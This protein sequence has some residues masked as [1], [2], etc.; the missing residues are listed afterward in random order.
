MLPIICV[1][2]GGACYRIAEKRRK[3]AA[4]SSTDLFDNGTFV[5]EGA[6]LF[7]R[8]HGPGGKVYVTAPLPIPAAETPP[9]EDIRGVP[10]VYSAGEVS[11]RAGFK[12][13]T[14]E[15]R[16]STT[17]RDR[18]YLLGCLPPARRA[19][20][21]QGEVVFL[22]ATTATDGRFVFIRFLGSPETVFLGTQLLQPDR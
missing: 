8:I 12:R 5:C 13:A 7:R 6:T 11:A 22:N 2:L 10:V 18:V 16:A 9:R 19:A 21:Q 3:V 15:G 17:G 20:A 14:I 1:P 4:G